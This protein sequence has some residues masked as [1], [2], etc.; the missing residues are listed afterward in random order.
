MASDPDSGAADAV[1][2]LPLEL[3]SYVL[4]FLP[5]SALATCSRAC[6][7]WHALAYPMLFRRVKVAAGKRLAVRLLVALAAGGARHVHCL[8][9]SDEDGT[10]AQR[11]QEGEVARECVAQC[12]R[13]ATR[14]RW[15]FLVAGNPIYPDL[16]G[17]LMRSSALHFV[18]LHFFWLKGSWSDVDL[19]PTVEDVVVSVAGPP[20]DDAITFPGSVFAM[21]ARA[22]GLKSW[23]A[24]FDWVMDAGAFVR[25]FPSLVGKLVSAQAHGF[26]NCLWDLGPAFSPKEIRI[27]KGSIDHADAAPA[28]AA[29]SL[30]RIV[31]DEPA[32]PSN[33][34]QPLEELEIAYPSRRLFFKQHN[35][36]FLAMLGA[37]KRVTVRCRQ[38][39]FVDYA[40]RMERVAILRRAGARVIFD[41]E[42]E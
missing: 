41:P 17:Q 35:P 21:L 37:A 34:P 28:H 26:W 23:T 39:M 14:L 6:R 7:E 11:G 18:E 22:K 4:S 32:E 10:H 3:V 1:P 33:L 29:R 27:R 30:V 42:P 9:I 15:W 40:E 8:E 13:H 19:P 24:E 36:G 16:P 5:H 2:S 20:N 12:L 38:N 25:K 31:L